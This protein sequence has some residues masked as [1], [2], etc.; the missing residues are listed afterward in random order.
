LMGTALVQ[1]LRHHGYWSMALLYHRQMD[2]IKSLLCTQTVEQPFVEQLSD[3]ALHTHTGIEVEWIY[4][5]I[6]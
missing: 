5:R 1:Y 6:T 2:S 4:V 3:C